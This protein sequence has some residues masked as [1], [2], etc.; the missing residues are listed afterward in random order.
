MNRSLLRLAPRY[1]RNAAL[2]CT[3]LMACTTVALAQPWQAE[4]DR[5]VAAA[6]KEGAVS[7]G[8]PQS[9]ASRRVLESFQ[10][11]YPDIKL[12]YK[13][14]HGEFWQRLQ[15]ERAAGIRDW[16][17]FVGGAAVPTYT[18]AKNGLLLP[19]R[20]G[21]IRPDILDDRNW[22]GGFDRA[23]GDDAKKHVFSFTADRL[24]LVSVNRTKVPEAQLR[25]TK[26]LLDPK[27]KGQIVMMD[28]RQQGVG[29]LVVGSL[30]KDLGDEAVRRII[31]ELEPV[32]TTDR[33]QAAEWVIRGR[34]PIGIGV[35]SFYYVPFQEQGLGKDIGYLEA[36]NPVISSSQSVV[37]MIAEPPHPNAAKVFLNW[38]L[39]RE[40]QEA[41]SKSTGNN[42]LRTDVPPGNPAIAVNA[43]QFVTLPHAN[44]EEGSKHFFQDSG[45]FA[46]SILK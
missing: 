2:L 44:T 14:I 37:V 28:P 7:V 30:R 8:G 4:W 45:E 34:Y 1:L 46:L 21:V 12:Q 6:K 13:G 22:S 25:S 23:F 20:S 27:W 32:F 16:D 35:V 5:V 17:I 26:Q 18:A 19:I 41:W 29:T 15:S 10:A 40:T 31:T 36:V 11:A 43:N 24:D 3:G 9:A 39:S 33:R 38:L 42:S